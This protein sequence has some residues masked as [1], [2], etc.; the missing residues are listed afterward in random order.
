[1]YA[2]I[3]T[4]ILRASHVPYMTKT[5]AKAIMKRKELELKYLKNETDINL[6]SCK[7]QRDFCSKLYKKE[8]QLLS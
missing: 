4:K 1:M 7:K 5:L 6:R 8:K 3:K 2:P